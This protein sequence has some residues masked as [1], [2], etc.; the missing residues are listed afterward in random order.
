MKPVLPLV[1]DAH[2]QAHAPAGS[3]VAGLNADL[4]LIVSGEGVILVDSGAS[5]LGAEKLAAAIRSAAEKPVCWVINP[6]RRKRPTVRGTGATP[7]ADK[8]RVIAVFPG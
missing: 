8:T 7:A 6:E 3:A 1:E 5:R 2:T 4:P